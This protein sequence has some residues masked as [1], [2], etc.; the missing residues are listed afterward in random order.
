MGALRQPPL[1]VG[2]RSKRK[3]GPSASEPYEQGQADFKEWKS[4]D[5]KDNGMVS[6]SFLANTPSS[7]RTKQMKFSFNPIKNTDKKESD[8]KK[9]VIAEA[10]SANQTRRVLLLTEPLDLNDAQWC[11]S[12]FISQVSQLYQEANQAKHAAKH[13]TFVTAKHT[14]VAELDKQKE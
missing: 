9:K 2:Q 6:F 1:P 5:D 11:R 13:G 14:S 4:E 7:A 8:L 3:L 10:T 12:D